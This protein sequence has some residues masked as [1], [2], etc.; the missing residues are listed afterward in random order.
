MSTYKY[1]P[2]YHYNGPTHA[3]P[4]REEL[5][6]EESESRIELFFSELENY[7]GDISVVINR[8][9]SNIVEITTDLTQTECDE[10][11]KQCLN[12]LDLFAHKVR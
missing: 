3:Q 10:I 11:V 4:L 1:N 12:S 8:L 5:T 9:P 2:Y 6:V 7:F